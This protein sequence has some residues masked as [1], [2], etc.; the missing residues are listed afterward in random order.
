[1]VPQTVLIEFVGILVVLRLVG[2]AVAFEFQKFRLDG[3]G[4]RGNDLV[5]QLE[6]VGEVAVVSL[7]HYV[8]ISVG[9][10]QLRRDPHPAARLAHA[11][12]ENIAH[13]QL[14]TDFLDVDCLPFVGEGRVAGDHRECAPAGEHRDDVLGDAIGE[15][16]LLRITA[17]VGEWQNRDGPLIVKARRA[18]RGDRPASTEIGGPISR[19]GAHPV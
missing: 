15:E 18:L 5:L 6:Q 1:M 14:L 4:D 8:M 17:E 2:N 7:G 9:A 16:L 13:A 11:A 19:L 12:L 3:V 10:D